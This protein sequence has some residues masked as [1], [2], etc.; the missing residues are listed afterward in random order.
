MTGNQDN[1]SRTMKWTMKRK[2]KFW[3][4]LNANKKS[5]LKIFK[6]EKRQREGG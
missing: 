1:E 6:L 3:K 5:L 2:E 4:R